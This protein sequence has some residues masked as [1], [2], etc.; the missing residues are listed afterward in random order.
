V[1]EKPH[2]ESPGSSRDWHAISS[3]P[4]TTSGSRPA[5]DDAASAPSVPSPGNHEIVG[6]AGRDRAGRTVFLAREL[7]S[8]SGPTTESSASLIALFARAPHTNAP[9]LETVRVLDRVA[10]AAPREC[11]VCAMPRNDAVRFCEACGATMSFVVDDTTH[12]DSAARL[13]AVKVATRE[14]LAVIGTMPVTDGDAIYFA[15]EPRP[16]SPLVALVPRAAPRTDGGV[17]QSLLDVM[18]AIDAIRP[19]LPPPPEDEAKAAGDLVFPTP[20]YDAVAVPDDPLIGGLIDGKYRILRKLGQGGMGVVFDARHEQLRARRAIKVMHPHLQSRTDLVTRFYEEA[21]NAERV[22]HEHVCTVHDFGASDGLIYIA[23]EFI[24]GE[25]LSAL[26]KRDGK[27]SPARV[28]V[29]V[30]QTAAALD[31]A[32]ALKI[33]HRDVKPD[34]IMLSRPEGRPDGAPDDVKVVDFGI[35]KALNRSE[36]TTGGSDTQFGVVIGTLDYMSDEQRRGEEIDCRTDVYALGRTAVK[37]LFGELPEHSFWKEW[38]RVRVNPAL[39]VVL[40]RALAPVAERYASAGDFSRDLAQALRSAPPDRATGWREHVQ[41]WSRGFDI[42]R[43]RP[44]VALAVLLAAAALAAVPAA[45][46]YFGADPAITAAPSAVRFEAGDGGVVPTT[47]EVR[48][49]SVSGKRI[50]GLGVDEIEYDG[51]TVDWLARP[52]WRNGN[53]TLPTTLVLEPRVGETPPGT[54]TARVRVVSAKSRGAVASI[55]ATLV[56]KGED[57]CSASQAQ[58]ARIRKLT[59]PLTGTPADARSVVTMVPALVPSLCS[60][61]EQVEAQLRLAEA[62]MTL[63]QA[64]RACEVLRG[65]ENQS[66]STPFATN[67]RVYLSRCR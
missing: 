64:A 38:S 55:T 3:G 35:S 13:D 4:D 15:R 28:S 20:A 25:P 22:K 2:D 42:A 8:S 56:V 60:P 27:V 36:L 66:A 6:T 45:S 53:A 59:D 23:M 67:V 40:S 7:A 48:I 16:D 43:R 21:R 18:P 51:P 32:H 11:Y 19:S 52:T 37:M 58:L 54:Y 57:K 49:S 5:Q 62:Y 29:I 44:G 24:D 31:A 41:R 14:Q 26:L 17:T 47:Q 46:R 33:I 39:A 30:G 61:S 10:V 65:V 9:A 34:N 63:S 50:D 1:P 12:G